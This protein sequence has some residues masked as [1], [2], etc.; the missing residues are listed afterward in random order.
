MRR[1]TLAAVGLVFNLGVKEL[2]HQL[3]RFSGFRQLEVIPEGVR[4]SFE[5][6]ELRVVSGAQQGSMEDGGIAEQ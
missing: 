2:G 6:D 1:E 3:E 4:Q 5:H